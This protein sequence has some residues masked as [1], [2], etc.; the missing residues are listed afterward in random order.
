MITPDDFAKL[1]I[2]VGRVLVVEHLPNP[3]YTTH[4]LTVDFGPEIGRKVSGARLIRYSGE[5][6][7]GRLILGVL[8]LPPKQI[9]GMMSEFLT[10]GVP[11]ASGEC[12]LIEPGSDAAVLGG[13]LY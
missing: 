8:N 3:R 9:G 12:V 2:R 4:K 1:E 11:D 10:L 6:L 5:Q 13:K 7:A